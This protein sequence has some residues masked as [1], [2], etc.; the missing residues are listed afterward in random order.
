MRKTVSEL[1]PGESVYD[2]DQPLRARYVHS[3]TEDDGIV[4]V[5]FGHP[6]GEPEEDKEKFGYVSADKEYEVIA[7]ADGNRLLDGAPPTM[8][9]AL[10]SIVEDQDLNADDRLGR[11]R[12][13]LGS[14]DQTRDA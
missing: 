2:E 13:V 11:I 3:V 4:V 9:D 6:D 1:R 5:R 12:D 10:R 14:L 8:M 7:G